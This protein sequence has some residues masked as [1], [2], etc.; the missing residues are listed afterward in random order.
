MEKA[1][2]MD[3]A[4]TINFFVIET[5][6]MCANKDPMA[7][8]AMSD[9]RPL[10]GL[11]I[12]RVPFAI[13]MEKPDCTRGMPTV[14]MI[15]VLTV[16]TIIFIG[17][18]INSIKAFGRGIMNDKKASG[19]QIAFTSSFPKRKRAT[20]MIKTRMDRPELKNT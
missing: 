10:H 4:N 2:G 3:D 12:S 7:R 14:S 16:A 11:S 1:M 18:L 8:N 15:L 19:N 17:K 13:S 5:V 9:L 20:P 6:Q